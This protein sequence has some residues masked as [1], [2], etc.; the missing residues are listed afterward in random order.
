MPN[1]VEPRSTPLPAGTWVFDQTQAGLGLGA[2]V[3]GLMVA[4]GVGAAILAGVGLF[5]AGL[6]WVQ[7]LRGDDPGAPLTNPEDG[8]DGG[9]DSGFDPLGNRTC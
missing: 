8:F 3:G 5:A 2:A 4:T 9:A 6:A 7:T 1:S